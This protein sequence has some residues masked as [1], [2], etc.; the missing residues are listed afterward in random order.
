IP[1]RKV[2]IYTEGCLIAF[3]A[4]VLIRRATENR[5][6]LDDV[7]RILY[8][9]FG[10][11]RRGYSEKDIYRII[12][13]VAERPMNEFLDQYAYGRTD[14]RPMLEECLE[15]LGLKIKESDSV[16]YTET[17][18]GFKSTEE[19]DKAIVRAIYPGSI[20]DIAGLMLNDQIIAVNGN[21]VSNNMDNWCRFYA[22]EEKTEITLTIFSS[23]RQK[24]LIIK[25]GI[26]LGFKNYAVE[27]AKDLIQHQET[28][29]KLWAGLSVY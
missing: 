2:S 10:K 8:N 19:G 12:E 4:D 3:M 18:L 20:A 23:F 9:D 6:S 13:K 27:K 26:S 24:E 15:Y 7:M 25:P 29:F 5:N 16:K 11:K 22:K 1:N 14:F 17:Y 21:R 28:S